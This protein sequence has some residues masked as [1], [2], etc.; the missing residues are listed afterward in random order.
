MIADSD[1]LY[2]KGGEGSMAVIDLFGPDTDGNGV[3]DQLEEIRENGWIIN[4][5]NLVFYVNN[6]IQVDAAQ[7]PQR[8][9][10]YNMDDAVPL[11][12]YFIDQTV[13]TTSPSLSKGVYG[14]ILERD[15]AGNATQYK[16]RITEHI[17]NVVRKDSTNVTLGL[18]AS[19]DIRI[20]TS[21]QVETGNSELDFVPTVSIIN[22]F[23]T[24]LYGSTPASPENKRLKLEIFYTIP[25]SN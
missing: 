5:A 25:E 21:G 6:N 24:V 15:A 12:D 9:Y 18:V 19:S 1:N 4:D 17:N 16:I 8:I 13:N 20:V 11:Q 22:P 3:A 10:L 7:D 2:L 23:G 14:G